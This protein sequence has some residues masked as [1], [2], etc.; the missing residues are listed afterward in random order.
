MAGRPVYLHIFLMPSPGRELRT[1][2]GYSA[3][4]VTVVSLKISCQL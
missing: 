2:A 4:R 1:L 3:L